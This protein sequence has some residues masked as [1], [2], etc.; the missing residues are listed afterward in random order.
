MCAQWAISPWSARA[1]VWWW[2][3]YNIEISNIKNAFGRSCYF[4]RSIIL[5]FSVHHV[6]LSFVS[7]S[8]NSELVESSIFFRKLWTEAVGWR[9]PTYMTTTS[10]PNFGTPKKNWNS[11]NVF[12]RSIMLFSSVHHVIFFGPSCYFFGPSYMMDRIWKTWWTEVFLWWT[13]ASVHHVKVPDLDIGESHPNVMP[14]KKTCNTPKHVSTCG[15]CVCMCA[16]VCV[17]VCVCVSIEFS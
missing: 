15:V 2:T 1:T 17:C 6:I 9:V 14:S 11:V 16:C 12:F 13:E 10:F 3:E 5:F 7:F 4:L 8:K